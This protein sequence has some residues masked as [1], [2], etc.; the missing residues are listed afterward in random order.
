MSS[1]SDF[2]DY[3]KQSFGEKLKAMFCCGEYDDDEYESSRRPALHIV[4]VS[5]RPINLYAIY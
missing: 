2:G 4:S 5:L 3:K 1:A